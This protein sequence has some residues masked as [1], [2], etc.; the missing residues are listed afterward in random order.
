MYFSSITVSEA[1]FRV[2][3]SKRSVTETPKKMKICA[4]A[5]YDQEAVNE[6]ARVLWM[7]PEERQLYFAAQQRQR[8]EEERQ[9]KLNR[10]LASLQRMNLPVVSVQEGVIVI[11]LNSRPVWGREP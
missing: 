3:R 11:D 9:R 1:F 7:E 8:K 10:V 5:G 2:S 4:D 6:Q